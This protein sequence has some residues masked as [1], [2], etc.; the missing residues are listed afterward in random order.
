MSDSD[1]HVFARVS[2]F[3]AHTS[4]DSSAKFQQAKRDLDGMLE[5]LRVQND[6]DRE[7]LRR[8]RARLTRVRRAKIRATASGDRGVLYEIDGELRKIL[9]R[10]RRI[11]AEM[12]SMQEDRNKISILVIEQ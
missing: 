2:S 6:E 10:L 9:I 12:V 7:T 1:R 3:S 5:K 11:D 8:F 4:G